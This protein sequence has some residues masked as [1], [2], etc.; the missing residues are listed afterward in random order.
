MIVG[1]LHCLLYMYTIQL[2]RGKIRLHFTPGRCVNGSEPMK[3]R[4]LLLLTMALLHAAANPGVIKGTVVTND[5][6]AISLVSVTL[7]PIPG[8]GASSSGT[9]KTD[10]FGAFIFWSVQPGAYLVSASRPGFVP[11]QYGQKRWNSAGKPLDV[12]DRG[13]VS[14]SIAMH[15]YGA[16]TGR[17]I[18]E[19]GVGIP[20]QEVMAFRDT[21]P[22]EMAAKA[23]ADDYGRYRI[24]GL[25]PGMYV[26]RSGPQRL[27]GADYVPTFAPGTQEL[28]HARRVEVLIDLE[29]SGFDLQPDQGRL[30][31]V[32]AELTPGPG[33]SPPQVVLAGETGRQVKQGLEVRFDPLP[34]GQYEIYANAPCDDAPFVGAYLKFA[35]TRDETLSIP[36]Q[37]VQRTNVSYSVE[38]SYGVP[39]GTKLPLLARTIDMAGPG[40]VKELGNAPRDPLLPAGRWQLLLQGE[41]GLAV[42][43]VNAPQF[44]SSGA[45]QPMI[46][47]GWNEVV[48]GDHN[49]SYIS[50]RLSSSAGGLMGAVRDGQDAVEGSPVYL[51]RYD[52]RER[53]RLTELRTTITDAH[54]NYS[55]D[56]LAPGTYRVLATFEYAS[57]DAQ[58]MDVSKA[59][60]VSIDRGRKLTQDLQLFVLQ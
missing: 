39:R 7:R 46:P 45:R 29:S 20:N 49:R 59:T 19:N 50:Y 25:M 36:M 37:L 44:A 60:D 31:D 42:V 10:R 40:D 24:Y 11:A 56:G 5:G 17:I 33:C 8:S 43:D 51:E 32:S 35:V 58:T 34:K 52:T 21:Q 9:V 30:F 18:D 1:Q 53:K 2:S 14:V 28:M 41:G 13:S 16:I 6:E 26:V 27:D 4:I 57:P 15:R 38:G 48:S 47:D 22:P 3:Q 55:F 54:G 12:P 23:S